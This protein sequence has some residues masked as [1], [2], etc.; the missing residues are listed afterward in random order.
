M[1]RDTLGTVNLIVQMGL[2]VFNVK[3]QVL[4]I[5]N[6][7]N[8]PLGRSFINM[9]GIVSST[10]HQLLKFAWK[11][12]ELVIHGEGRHSNGHAP[13]I[14]K[15]SRDCD[16]YMI[17]LINATGDD[18]SPQPPMPDVYKMIAL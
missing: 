5:N 14:D 1:H 10:L 13:I 11:D 8:N 6:S 17:Q 18:L 16:F 4:D 9:A 3:C 2:V 15:F 12:Q 7:Y